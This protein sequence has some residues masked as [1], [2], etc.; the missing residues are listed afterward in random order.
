MFR[1][2]QG[3][4]SNWIICDTP[5]LDRMTCRQLHTHMALSQTTV[6]CE[7]YTFCLVLFPGSGGRIT[8][9]RPAIDF[10]HEI[11]PVNYYVILNDYDHYVKKSTTY[12]ESIKTKLRREIHVPLQDIV[13]FSSF[14]IDAEQKQPKVPSVDFK[15]YFLHQFQTAPFQWTTPTIIPKDM[16]TQENNVEQQVKEPPQGYQE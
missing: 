3:A 6:P 12:L 7:K 11:Q 14:Q 4:E 8:N 1:Q 10:L 5:A 13:L 2:V 15:K 16:P 9:L